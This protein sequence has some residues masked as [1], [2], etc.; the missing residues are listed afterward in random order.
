MSRSPMSAQSVTILGAGP[1]GLSAALALNDRGHTV[2]ILERNSSGT[3]ESRAVAV[4]RRSLRHFETVD[5]SAPILE[6]GE[7]VRCAR[8]FYNGE[9]LTALQIPLPETGPPAMVALPQDV[10]EKILAE[11]LSAQGIEVAWSTEARD[12]SQTTGKATVHAKG[13][14]GEIEI[15]SDFVLGADGSRSITRK[16]LGVAFDGRKYDGEWELID[17]AVDWPW[18]DA[19]IAAHFNDP[20]SVLFMVTLGNGRFRAIGNSHNVEEN[21]RKLMPIKDINWHN[22]FTLSERCV[23]RFGKG[24]IWLAGDAAHIHSPVGGM[25][26]NLGIDD[27]FDFAATVGTGDFESYNTR[28]LKAANIVMKNADRG[29]R[30]ITSRSGFVRRLRNT[31]LRT[32]G[33]SPYLQGVLFRTVLAVDE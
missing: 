21:V 33:A 28:R 4:N 25:G 18:P 3:N 9:P 12:I 22:Q 31:L 20:A 16:T 19:G 24:R 11:R 32:L 17:V 13:P 14:D 2:R 5:A 10:T 8:F 7:A 26:M 23:D 15:E 1:T 30:L 27:A 6:V 29:F